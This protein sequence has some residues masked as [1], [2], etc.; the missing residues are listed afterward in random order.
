MDACDEIAR[1]TDEA[2]HVH[3]VWWGVGIVLHPIGGAHQQLHRTN[4]VSAL[5]MGEPDGELCEPLPELTLL[6]GR[7][8]PRALQHLVGLEGSTGVE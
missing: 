7:G 6:A 5:H 3:A 4:R 2:F 1:P 8:L